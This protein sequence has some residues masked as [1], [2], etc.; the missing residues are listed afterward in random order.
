MMRVAETSGKTVDEAVGRALAQLG[1]RREQVDVDVIREGSKGFLGIG[2]EESIVRVTAKD[3]VITTAARPR[4]GGP[5]PTYP[6]HPARGPPPTAA[7]DAAG[8]QRSR[9][10]RGGRGRSG[11]GEPGARDTADRGP[12]RGPDRGPDRAGVRPDG[13]RAEYARPA[14]GG[15]PSRT[16]GRAREGEPRARGGGVSPDEEVRIPG[17]PDDLPY[18]PK[19]DATDQLDLAGTTL[20][21]ILTL[22]GLSATEI[23]ARDPET[24]GDGAGL[25][26]QVFDIFGEDDETA[27]E[28]GVL[29][30]RRGETLANLQYLLNTVVSRRE[31]DGPIYG[32]DIEGYR[33]RRE[34]QLIEMAREVAAEV[35]ATGDVITL[36]PMP[37]SERR[38]IHLSLQDE[39]GVKTESVGSGEH[40]QV[41]IMPA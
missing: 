31:K 11:T 22:L 24:A 32:L 1:L 37:A 14:G 26:A 12:G 3:S 41:E 8:G 30:G 6:P 20:R 33:R 5:P 13:R 34:Q 4:R 9:G 16:D 38:I 15:R 10:R 2:A 17:A 36:E 27:D 39:E 23:T 29:I 18:A 25:I 19:S 40:R 21:D 28:L 7:P 35:R